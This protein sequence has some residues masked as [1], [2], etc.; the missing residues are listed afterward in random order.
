MGVDQRQDPALVMIVIVIDFVDQTIALVDD[1]FP[2]ARDQ[3]F[4]AQLGMI[5]KAFDGCGE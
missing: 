4:S 2:G 5:D 1:E 3:T